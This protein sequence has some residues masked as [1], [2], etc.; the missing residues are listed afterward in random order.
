MKNGRPSITGLSWKLLGRKEYTML[1]DLLRRK[2]D[3]SQFRCECG[4]QA[5]KRTDGRQYIC[6][7][8][9]RRDKVRLEMDAREHNPNLK[10]LEWASPV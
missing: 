9:I 2:A 3:P 8:C 5:V 7:E 10:Y 1:H 4:K 6:A